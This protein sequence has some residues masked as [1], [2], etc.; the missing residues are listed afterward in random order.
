M[1]L[2]DVR[3][4]VQCRGMASGTFPDSMFCSG[5]PQVVADRGSPIFYKRNNGEFRLIGIFTELPGWLNPFAKVYLD[6]QWI[7]YN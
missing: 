3:D 2:L 7:R 5:T 1:E 6:F 4:T